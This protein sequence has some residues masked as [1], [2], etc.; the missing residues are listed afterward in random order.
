[1]RSRGRGWLPADRPSII[2]HP[3][4]WG[5]K[6]L[7]SKT[8]AA[9]LWGLLH[10]TRWAIC[11]AFCNSLPLV[12]P[13]PHRLTLHPPWGWSWR[14]RP[15]LFVR[16]SLLSFASQ[17]TDRRWRRLNYHRKTLPVSVARYLLANCHR[18]R[19]NADILNYG[20]LRTAEQ[21]SRSMCGRDCM[22]LQ[23]FRPIQRRTITS[24]MT[25]AAVRVSPFSWKL[26]RA[27]KARMSI[28]SRHISWV[29]WLYYRR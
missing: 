21:R 16:L 29:W 18:D 1:M 4:R 24:G 27:R 15:R 28:H 19:Y 25:F 2:F 5:C 10:D 17:R 6:S 22:T 23:K 20:Q 3:R 9:W 11:C 14:T 7:G 8:R 13:P 12:H 26:W